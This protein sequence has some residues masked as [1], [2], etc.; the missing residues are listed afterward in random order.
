[1]VT[2]VDDDFTLRAN[3]E[4]YRRAYA[5]RHHQGVGDRALSRTCQ[6]GS[7]VNAYDILLR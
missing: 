1:M 7:Y 4:G 6:T 5:S 2:G 3:S